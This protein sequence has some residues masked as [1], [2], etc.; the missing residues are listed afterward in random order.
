MTELY[1]TNIIDYTTSIEPKDI[2]KNINATLSKRLK[3]EIEGKCI[4]EGYVKKGSIKIVNR[5]LGEI[6]SSHFNGTILYHIKFKAEICNPVEG[7]IIDV[8]VVNI[9]KMGIL[10][11]YGDEEIPPLVI[12]LAKQHHIDNDDFDS[13]KLNDIIRIKVIGKRY[14]YGDSQISI[15]GVLNDDSKSE[16]KT[17]N[18]V[19]ST[20]SISSISDLDG[21]DYSSADD[22]PENPE[23]SAVTSILKSK[24]NEDDEPEDNEDAEPED[25][26]DAEP[27]SGKQG[28][29]GKSVS[30]ADTD[31]DAD[32]D[33]SDIKK[34][35]LKDSSK[36]SSKSDEPVS[37]EIDL[38]IQDL[39]INDND[40]D[41]DLDG[42]LDMNLESINL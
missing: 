39:D 15:I 6:L 34:I 12:L 40:L 31:A 10:A 23:I 11:E 8:K 41:L 9:N 26:E 7:M 3:N 19:S 17:L 2:N 27:D 18:K 30:E 37:D 35:V 24:S 32:A 33:G 42:D 28:T 38:N 22:E 36:K 5:S 13:I 21:P 4:K 25:N 20:S 14:E 29:E 1:I 16:I